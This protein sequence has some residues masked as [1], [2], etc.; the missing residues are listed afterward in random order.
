MTR[1][2]TDLELLARYWV[3]KY[4][5]TVHREPDANHPPLIAVVGAEADAMGTADAFG[6]TAHTN[7]AFLAGYLGYP[8][9]AAYMATVWE[10][11]IESGRAVLTWAHCIP[12]RETQVL[13]LAW[14]GHGWKPYDLTAHYS[15]NPAEFTAI[16]YAAHDFE[17]FPPHPESQS[18][19][20]VARD[21]VKRDNGNGFQAEVLASGTLLARARNWTPVR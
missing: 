12:T 3:G 20:A 11:T 21:M 18:M 9:D 19:R 17:Q 14:Q 8:C 5:S 13:S 15:E 7:M 4:A 16:E 2:L 1:Q 10:H 6:D